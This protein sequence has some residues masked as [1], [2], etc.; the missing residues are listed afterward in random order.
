[1]ESSPTPAGRLDGPS[2]WIGEDL[3]A[4]P[5]AWTWQLDDAEIQELIDA[6]APWADGTDDVPLLST[7]E[8]P[9]PHLASKIDALRQR[10]IRGRG[11]ELIRGLPVWDLS[12]RHVAAIFLAVGAHLGSPRSQN[13]AGHLLGHVRDL[14]LDASDPTVRIYQTSER[15]T[16]H[17]D[18]TDVVGLLCQQTAATGGT[19]L[20]VSAA[21][22]WNRL[23]E[24]S[25]KLAPLLFEPIA[26]DRRGE[27]PPGAQPWFEIPVLNWFDD[28]L[29]VIYQRQYI[30][31]AQ[32]FPEI[33]PLPADL[34][35]ALDQFDAIAN[36]PTV[37]LR[38]DLAPG[39]MQFVHNH[40]M[41]HD[42]TSFVNKPDAPRHLLRL[43]LSV[44]G[45]RA[46]PPSFAQRY[47]SIAVGDRGGIIT[48]RTT[49]LH[50]PV[51]PRL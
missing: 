49:Q 17:T 33:D 32:R 42:R 24:E 48:D 40:S 19:S 36:D 51:N 38:M 16:F 44:A 6:T 46:L 21:T 25:P 50:A 28:V 14:S 4:D 3:A 9:L 45:D 23:I 30:E 43:W 12:D 5:H 8:V 7:A 47:G 35:A 15:Q 26:T 29:T 41:L 18:S 22:I 39:D 34:V 27:I 10:L 2:A 37:H 11:F 1:M 31:S 20:L 13:A